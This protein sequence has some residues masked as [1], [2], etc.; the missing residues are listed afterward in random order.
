MKTLR[1]LLPLVF[2]CCLFNTSRAQYVTI[3]D[4]NF[5]SW[6]QANHPT[7]MNGNQMD[8]TCT[9][10]TRAGVVT[11]TYGTVTDLTGI[12]YFD[13]LKTLNCEHNAITTIPALPAYCLDINVS[14]NSLG[15]LPALPQGLTTLDISNNLFYSVPALPAGLISLNCGYNGADSLPALP[16][17]LQHLYCEN[18]NVLYLPPLPASLIDLDC[19]SNRL[20]S[21]PALPAT[22]LTLNCDNNNLTTL[23][24]LSPGLIKLICGN[25]QLASLPALPN[26]ITD[27]DIGTGGLTTL[28]ALPASLVDLSVSMASLT[29]LPALPSGLQ[30]LTVTNTQITTL[31]ALPDSLTHIYVRDNRI[32]SLPPLP[33]SLWLLYC[34]NNQ[35]TTLPALPKAL[36]ILYVADNLLTS[37]PALPDEFTELDVTGNPNLHC[38]PRLTTITSLSFD[39]ANITCVPNFG[40]V[41]ISSPM[42]NTKPICNPA[43]PNSC[44][45][46]VS[47]GGIVY[48]DYDN[49]CLQQNST[50]ALMD[51]KVN[52]LQNGTL[53]QQVHTSFAGNYTFEAD[54]GTYTITVDTTGIPF[55]VVCPANRFDSVHVIYYDTTVHA[56][57]FGMHCKPGCDAGIYDLIIGA[58]ARPAS[59]T[60]VYLQIMEMATLYGQSCRDSAVGG[61]VVVT[62]SGPVTYIGPEVMRLTPVVNGNVLTY[63]IDDWA[64]VPQ[65]ACDFVIQVDTTAQQGQQVCVDVQ[66][67]PTLTDNNL[68]NNYMSFCEPVVNSFDPNDKRVL[69]EGNIDTADTNKWLTYKI[70]FQ[71][72]G[73]ASAQNISITDTL[74]AWLDVETFEVINYSYAPSVTI[75]G[76]AVRFNFPFI[77]LPDS[78]SNEPG[79][80]GYVEYKVKI[81]D[82]APVGT[83]ITN[84]AF[85]YFDFNAPVVTNTTTN[86]IT[87]T[88]P[89]GISSIKNSTATML[90]YPNPANDV[91]MINLSDNLT[92]GT[93]TLSDVTGRSLN[94]ITVTSNHNQLNTGALASGVYLVT[95]VKG[96]V[97]VVQ[98]LVVSK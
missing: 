20:D 9:S 26:S 24:N 4:A 38:L 1:L 40:N 46:L 3:P 92:G 37:V 5:V 72:T 6:L 65:N 49:T 70:R 61:E 25:P 78:N 96:G 62:L 54:T 66:I 19:R 83:V 2:F 10:I 85:I 60:T 75:A 14:Y 97:R 34:S 18:M 58:D 98:R 45:A 43:N 21:L 29:T 23:P 33:P 77:N 28:P 13:S 79:S 52:L 88:Q 44:P 30:N 81:K 95:A 48:R 39:D 32:T 76:N 87:I 15:T 53:V 31:P 16:A 12:N 68:T 36:R 84:T 35:L 67:T 41:S 22:L 56:H 50:D 11:I 74:H 27:L 57:N 7:C 73:N 64:T 55:D 69:P 80:H 51:V 89:T 17:L 63:T 82:T 47:V 42:L 8:T 94:T 71:N 91:V 59:I 93:L 90:T 86:T